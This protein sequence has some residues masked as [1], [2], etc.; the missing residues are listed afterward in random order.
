MIS[1]STMVFPHKLHISE[2]VQ[3]FVKPILGRHLQ[4]MPENAVRTKTIMLTHRKLMT[5]ATDV[6]VW[7]KWHSVKHLESRI[8]CSPLLSQEM[9]CARVSPLQPIHFL[10]VLPRCNLNACGCLSLQFARI[11]NLDLL[12]NAECAFAWQLMQD[13]HIGSQPAMYS[14][15]CK[16]AYICCIHETFSPMK[17][18]AHIYIPLSMVL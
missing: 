14:P 3:L 16:T 10:C 12:S 18:S 7:V 17:I 8:Q 15:I 13:V 11:C 6:G 5:A 9:T 4:M 1:H 2:V